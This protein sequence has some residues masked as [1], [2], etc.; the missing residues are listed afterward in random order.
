MTSGSDQV[1]LHDLRIW[2]ALVSNVNK[3]FTVPKFELLGWWLVFIFHVILIF[4][5]IRGKL[6]WWPF[7]K[8]IHI[9]CSCDQFNSFSLVSLRWE[10]DHR[11]QQSFA[12]QKWTDCWLWF[13]SNPNSSLCLSGLRVQHIGTFLQNK[14]PVVVAD[15]HLLV[16]QITAFFNSKFHFWFFRQIDENYTSDDIS[17]KKLKVFRGFILNSIILQRFIQKI[18]DRNLQ[19]WKIQTL[20]KLICAYKFF[21][22]NEKCVLGPPFFFSCFLIGLKNIY[23][24]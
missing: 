16:L 1:C 8:R 7:T 20:R 15:Y 14:Q 13:H 10:W 6:I 4:F 12:L 2:T 21:F 9:Y 3:T 23:R 18:I 5:F 24:F 19:Y 17:M 22:F 11:P